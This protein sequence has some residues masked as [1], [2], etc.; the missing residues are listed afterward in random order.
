MMNTKIALKWSMD[1]IKYQ[2]SLEPFY[3]HVKKAEHDAPDLSQKIPYLM[4][5]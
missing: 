4:I 1:I 3:Y 5:T 2:I